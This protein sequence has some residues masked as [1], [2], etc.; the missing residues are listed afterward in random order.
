MFLNLFIR[1]ASTN[2]QLSGLGSML[3]ILKVSA[4]TRYW[5]Y[6]S[7]SNMILAT[8]LNPRYKFFFSDISDEPSETALVNMQKLVE[9]FDKWQQAVQSEQEVRRK[10]EADAFSYYGGTFAGNDSEV[11]VQ[12]QGNLVNL[13]S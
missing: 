7:D 10:E 6:L 4:N 3:T 1:K 13:F 9:T 12:L 11:D 8:F 2:A 5:K